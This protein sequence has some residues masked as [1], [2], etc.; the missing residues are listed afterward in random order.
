[1]NLIQEVIKGV[2]IFPEVDNFYNGY[3]LLDA[4]AAAIKDQNSNE[5]NDCLKD[6]IIISANNTDNL[7]KLIDDLV[8]NIIK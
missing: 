5:Y 2:N 7:M 6:Q 4:C 8:D 1:M 3:F